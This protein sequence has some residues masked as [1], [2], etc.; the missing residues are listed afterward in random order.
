MDYQK[1][2]N[3][4]FPQVTK[5]RQAGRPCKE[6]LD[7]VQAL[8]NAAETLFAQYGFKSTTVRDIAKAADVNH[9]LVIHHF[10]SKENLWNA[11]MDQQRIYLDSFISDL[12][13]LQK[14]TKTPIEDR[15][16][17][18]FQI[19]VNAVCGKPD[20]GLL[21]SRI[22]SESGGVFDLLIGK[23]LIPFHDAFIPILNESMEAGI[24]AKQDIE[25]LYFLIFCSV[26]S[27][28]SFRHVLSDFD[29]QQR[30]IKEFQN[31]IILFLTTNI[32]KNSGGV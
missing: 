5:S 30:N 29:K 12:K 13:N 17:T 11:V 7:G 1:I 27:S 6:K 26:T 22:G 24:I 4:E 18:A 20:C 10:G 19:L 21:L 8:L 14:Q 2:T 28:I 15:I 16:I 32:L 9:T 25:M 23:L 3:D 31:D